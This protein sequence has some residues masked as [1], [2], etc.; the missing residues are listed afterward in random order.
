MLLSVQFESP[1]PTPR[2]SSSN[3]SNG[4]A[5]NN[6]SNGGEANNEDSVDDSL[7]M[8]RRQPSIKDRKKVWESLRKSKIPLFNGAG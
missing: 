8:L 7:A 1:R 6:G 2:Q 5:A 3:S 4:H